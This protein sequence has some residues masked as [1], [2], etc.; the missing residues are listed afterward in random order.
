MLRGPP[1]LE[2]SVS[3]MLDMT[4]KCANRSRMKPYAA[5]PLSGPVGE[6]AAGLRAF[7]AEGISHLQL[8]LV[9]NTIKSVE[10]FAAVLDMLDHCQAVV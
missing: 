7:A 5:G 10:R 2:R 4:G 1:M 3:I 9:L 8:Y 6:I